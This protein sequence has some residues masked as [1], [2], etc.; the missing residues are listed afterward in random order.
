MVQ[1]KKKG[2]PE[3]RTVS[4]MLS[5]VSAGFVTVQAG[6]EGSAQ[7]GSEF[8]RATVK[9]KSGNMQTAIVNLKLERLTM[10]MP[11]PT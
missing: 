8:S 1:R 7:P 2:L 11:L 5:G 10:R 9:L 6:I 3:G 4:D